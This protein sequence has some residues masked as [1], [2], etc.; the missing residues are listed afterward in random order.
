MDLS[1]DAYDWLAFWFFVI[2]LALFGLWWLIDYRKRKRE[3]SLLEPQF[4]I[5]QWRRDIANMTPE[6]R[7]YFWNNGRDK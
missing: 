2:A 6:D 4:G 7:A 3:A 5:D 1:A